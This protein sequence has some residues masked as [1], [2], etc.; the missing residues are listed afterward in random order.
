[1]FKREYCWYCKIIMA[2]CHIL[3]VMLGEC[4]MVARPRLY[5]LCARRNMGAGIVLSW[6]EF[7][8]RERAGG[9]TW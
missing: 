8:T 1:M 5:A 4:A 3:R 2:N 6:S 9:V 7:A